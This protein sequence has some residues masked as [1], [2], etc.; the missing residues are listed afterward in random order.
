MYCS[1]VSPA[2][3]AHQR[4]YVSLLGKQIV[5]E[6]AQDCAALGEFPDIDSWLSKR[7][8]AQASCCKWGKAGWGMRSCGR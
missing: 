7:S 6:P 1:M 5:N 2:D 3:K 4:E 8:E